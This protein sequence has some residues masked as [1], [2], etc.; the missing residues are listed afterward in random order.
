MWNEWI[1]K[2]K[3]CYLLYWIIC[4]FKHLGLI[5]L[6]KLLSLSPSS[7]LWLMSVV[8]KSWFTS[9]VTPIFSLQWHV[10]LQSLDLLGESWRKNPANINSTLCTWRLE[11]SWISF[12]EKNWLWNL[13]TH[14]WIA[15]I[16]L[17]CHFRILYAFETN[18]L[19]QTVQSYSPVLIALFM[20]A[21]VASMVTHNKSRHEHWVRGGR[22]VVRKEYTH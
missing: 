2:N 11:L 7:V 21:L 14:D 4:T 6:H 12:C 9:F 18:K 15:V 10:F 8:S 20:S 5:Q 22:F 16:I 3:K 13:S 19:C 1:S 17:S